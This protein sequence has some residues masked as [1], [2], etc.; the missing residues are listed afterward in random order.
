MTEHTLRH[1]KSCW[2]PQIFDRR[3]HES[4]VE[5]GR[6]TALDTARTIARE[7]VARP[8]NDPLPA[9]TLETLNDIVAAADER[10]R[11]GNA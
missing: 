7:V 4:W 6:P 3:S 10:A 5:A 8:P 2:Y 9:M 1:Y 11:R